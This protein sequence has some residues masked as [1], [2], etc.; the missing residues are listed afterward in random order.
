MKELIG[1]S[2]KCRKI[3]VWCLLLVTLPGCADTQGD[4][5]YMALV[6]SF[7]VKVNDKYIRGTIDETL[8]HIIL[9]GIKDGSLITEVEYVLAGGVTIYPAPETRVNDWHQE[10][11]FFITYNGEQVLYT[12]I[13]A[14][15]EGPD[16]EENLG[17]AV[18]SPEKYYGKQ[19]NEFFYDLKLN[20]NSINTTDKANEFFVEDAMNGVRIPIYGDATRPAHPEQGKIDDSYYSKMIVSVNNAKIARGDN[21]L[22]IFASKKLD[23]KNSFP[24]WVKDDEGVIP[25]KYGQ[26]LVDYI[27]YMKGKDIIIDVLGIDNETNFNEGNITPQKHMQIVDYLKEQSTKLN[28]K[29]PLIVGPERYEPMG[30]A[31]NCWLKQF[32]DNGWG[33]R[34]DIY[35]THYYPEHRYY[36]KLCYELSLIGERP[37]WATE[38]HWP[39][40]TAQPDVLNY[41]ETAI[42][43]LWDQTDLGVDGF[44]WWDYKRSGNLRGC[45]MRTVSAPLLGARPIEMTDHDGK[46][47]F[48]KGRL[49]TRAFRKGDLLNVFAINTC[50]KDEISG[51]VSYENYEFILDED[52]ITG[53]VICTQ[54][55]D[56]TP[57]EGEKS[58]AVK[59]GDKKFSVDLPV[60]SITYLQ[61]E[62]QS[63]K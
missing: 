59:I 13:L 8:N 50:P 44:M 54:W 33:D 55:R 45:L 56:G 31:D 52:N 41:A 42:C 23:G 35:G 34:I 14:D 39:S 2:N 40:E 51:A 60:R 28:F 38:P 3:L 22:T 15:Y 11:R 63:V 49:Q 46:D 20:A 47:T 27:L 17:E 25:E 19:I 32:I 9:K 24:D 6:K 5:A 29:M 48:K 37:F 57:I 18:I 36:D 53:D 7:N 21:G 58:V 12:V 61:F 16:S 30:D 62:I 1:F 10:E 4:S 26:M 43:T